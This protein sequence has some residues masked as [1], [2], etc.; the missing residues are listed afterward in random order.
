M[1]NLI[2]IHFHILKSAKNNVRGQPIFWFFNEGGVA[3]PGKGT[4]R[5]KVKA[6]SRWCSSLQLQK[7]CCTLTSLT[8]PGNS[9]A[10]QGGHAHGRSEEGSR[11][12]WHWW[13]PEAAYISWAQLWGRFFLSLLLLRWLSK[14]NGRVIKRSL[15]S[16]QCLGD[17]CMDGCLNTETCTSVGML[18]PPCA[19]EVS[20]NR[21]GIY[22]A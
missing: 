16:P 17:G 11:W 18:V 7:Q 22:P 20:F 14:G 9:K 15:S 6:L 8:H 19:R 10:R 12:Q 1:C 2:V 13:I 4:K 3:R 5:K 21:S